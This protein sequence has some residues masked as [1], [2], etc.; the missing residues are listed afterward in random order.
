[1][2]LRPIRDEILAS[3]MHRSGW[4][5]VMKSL[6]PLF[7]DSSSVIFDDFLEMTFSN[8]RKLLQDHVY[9]LPWMGVVHHPPDPPC[10]YHTERLQVLEHA[11]GWKTSIK[12]FRLCIALEENLA[13]WVRKNWNVPCVV[14]RHPTE[15]PEMQWTPERFNLNAS[16][17]LLQVGWYLRNTYAIHQVNVDSRFTKAWLRQA[18][19]EILEN[20]RL[21]GV[22]AFPHRKHTGQVREISPVNNS[23]YDQLLSENIVFIELF[24]AAA[25]NTIIECIARNTP[26][27]INRLAGPEYYLGP[28]YP[29][30]S[31]DIEDLNSFVT[32]DRVIAAHEYLKAMDKTWLSADS[33]REELR[34]ACLEHFPEF[35]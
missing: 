22:H 7:D 2:R 21:C 25:N 26:I 6:E 32:E 8:R 31:E 10:W 3:H 15:V 19:A 28:E 1:M 14:A 11:R 29:L 34:R 16:K 18:S 24:S 33:F 23:E 12:N 20:H 4:P 13:S 27:V 17:M 5:F 9:E 30:F 35:V